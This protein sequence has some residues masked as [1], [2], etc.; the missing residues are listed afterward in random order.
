MPT[1]PKSHL[2]PFIPNKNKMPKREKGGVSR[3]MWMRPSSS[4][5]TQSS[6]CS[7]MSELW[8][9]RAASRL[10]TVRPPCNSRLQTLRPSKRCR[11]HTQSSLLTNAHVVQASGKRCVHASMEKEAVVHGE[12]GAC[13]SRRR[14]VCATCASKEALVC[15]LCLVTS[16]EKEALVCRT[17]L[18]LHSKTHTQAT[19]YTA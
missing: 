7:W 10:Q 17:L 5:D 4:L 18:H 6:L 15:H 11:L 16:M 9:L 12:G 1:Q 14:H 3:V 8:V 19:Q 13:V 2:Q